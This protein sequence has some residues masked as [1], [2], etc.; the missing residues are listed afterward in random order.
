MRLLIVIN[1]YDLQLRSIMLLYS[2][3]KAGINPISQKIFHTLAFYSNTLSKVF[4]LDA[5]DGK[6]LKL[7]TGPYYPDLQ[8]QLDYLI[9]AGV[10][11]VE[12]SNST[13]Y[14]SRNISYFIDM[15]FGKSIIANFSTLDNNRLFSFIN[16]IVQAFSELDDLEIQDSNEIDA[17]YADKKTGYGNVIDFEEWNDYNP[18]FNAIQFLNEHN[19]EFILTNTVKIKLYARQIQYYLSNQQGTLNG[20]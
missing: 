9:C 13:D 14:D 15:D 10:V 11:T 2:A 12:Y 16:D 19:S 5:L 20:R 3:H 6:I 7:H 18:T 4:G 8:K 1:Y 17:T